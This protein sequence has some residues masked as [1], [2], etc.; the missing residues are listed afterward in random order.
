MELFGPDEL[1]GTP[2]DQ[3]ND[4]AALS[5]LLATNRVTTNIMSYPSDAHNGPDLLRGRRSFGSA[6]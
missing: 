1:S 6:Q 2:V 5:P 4:E 3:P